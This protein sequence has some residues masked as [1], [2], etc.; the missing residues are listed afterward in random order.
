MT[1]TL[2]FHCKILKWLYLRNGRV[3]SLGMRE[4]GVSCIWC[5]MHKGI[6]T[7]PQ[8]MANRSGKWWVNVKLLQFPTCLPMNGLFVHWSRGWGVL[9]FSERLVYINLKT[10]WLLV[11]RYLS[12]VLVLLVW[13]WRRVGIYVVTESIFCF[14]LF[15]KS[16]TASYMRCCH[17]ISRL[18]SRRYS[19]HNNPPVW[20]M[21]PNVHVGSL[22]IYLVTLIPIV[23][24]LVCATAPPVR[25]PAKAF[26]TLN[27]SVKTLTVLK[28]SHNW[29]DGVSDHQPHDYLLNRL[30]RR[31]SKKTSKLRV[32]GLC[33]GNSPVIGEFPEQRAS[34]AE[35]VSI[36]WR[37]RGIHVPQ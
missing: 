20:A 30:F 37:H 31:R 9:S 26:A 16:D 5:W 12:L 23:W 19:S 32:T 2:D 28:W 35:N 6:D 22:T 4:R 34:N 8:C 14:V 13:N 29:R 11:R 1:L 25:S 36:W 18:N 10:Y 15:Y 7:G 24:A 21:H 3:D 33:A 17:R 27:G